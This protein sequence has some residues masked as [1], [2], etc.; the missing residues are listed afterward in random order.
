[1]RQLAFFLAF[2]LNG[3]LLADMANFLMKQGAVK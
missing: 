3:E 2:G 1:M